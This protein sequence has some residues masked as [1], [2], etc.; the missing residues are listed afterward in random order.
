MGN[1]HRSDPGGDEGEGKERC[2]VAPC[3]CGLC[4]GDSAL[5][6]THTAHAVHRTHRVVAA[7]VA[8]DLPCFGAFHHIT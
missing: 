3:R 1:L 4:K 2:K 7:R 5:P 6:S 8:W